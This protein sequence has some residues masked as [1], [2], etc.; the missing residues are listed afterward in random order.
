MGYRLELQNGFEDVRALK[1][2]LS[3]NLVFEPIDSIFQR[4]KVQTTP[5]C[6]EPV[7]SSFSLMRS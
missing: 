1:V 5:C 3:T 4:E 7:D 2:P 6:P